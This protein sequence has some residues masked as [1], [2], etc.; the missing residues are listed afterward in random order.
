[1]S[2]QMLLPGQT[3]IKQIT[4]VRNSIFDMKVSGSTH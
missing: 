4:N 3:I 2:P 1:M